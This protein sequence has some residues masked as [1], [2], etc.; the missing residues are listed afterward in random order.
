M[1]NLVPVSSAAPY[2]HASRAVR[3]VGADARVLF[4]RSSYTVP[5]AEA[6]KTVVVEHCGQKIV[7]RSSGLVI[8]EHPAA[9]R[10]GMDVSSKEHIADLW[11]LSLARAPAP[12][13]NWNVVFSGSVEER[14]L[15]VYEK[16]AVQA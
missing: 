13:R 11:K 9:T 6:G 5:P 2:V 16:E 3:K 7:I 10:A 15:E 4:G 14:P 1:E 12:E 8:A